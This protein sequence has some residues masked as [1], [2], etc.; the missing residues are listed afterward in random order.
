MKNGISLLAAIAAMLS[1][2]GCATGPTIKSASDP[3]FS[4]AGYKTFGVMASSQMDG[5]AYL[6]VKGTVE[7]SIK[8]GFNAKG[9]QFVEDPK[10]ASFVVV[11]KGKSVPKV[12]VV[13]WG[14]PSYSIYSRRGGWYRTYP[15]GGTDVVQWEEG[16]LT[17]EVYDVAKKELVWAGWATGERKDKPDLARL[18]KA[19]A[20]IIA[21]FPAKS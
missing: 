5:G 13:D 2:W 15:M 7:S 18:S 3:G 21:Q 11:V 16:T 20:D 19:I 1:L 6:Q 12:D 4:V 8:S 10:T 17:L 14:Y 9:F